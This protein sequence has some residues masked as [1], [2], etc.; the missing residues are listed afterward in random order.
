MID[1]VL[2][3]LGFVLILIGIIG[4]FVPILPGPPLSYAGM[5]VIHLSEKASFSPK[6]L[7]Y[8]GIIALIITVVDYILPVIGTK[9]TGGTK[10]GVIGASLGLIVGIIFFPPIGIIIGPLAGAFIA[11][12]L[13]KQT[14]NTAI[15]SAIGS[16]LGL[17]FGV[18][19]KLIISTIIAW[20]AIKALFLG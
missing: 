11:E 2:I 6:T 10:Y 3:S 4:A 14:S 12:I 8:V 18:V 15:R 17:M 7:I 9:T 20:F 13:N 16:F 5:I 1:I 19:L